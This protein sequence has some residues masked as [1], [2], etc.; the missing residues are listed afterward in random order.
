[1]PQP[2]L[3]ADTDDPP[4][5]AD[6]ISGRDVA[7]GAWGTAIV[8]RIDRPPLR[9]KGRRL[10]QHWCAT[11]GDGR[12]IIELWQRQA[13]GFVV[14]H[15]SMAATVGRTDGVRV[16]DLDAAMSYLEELCHTQ[17]AEL[18]LSGD[19]STVL[20]TLHS[21]IHFDQHFARL[22]GTALEDWSTMPQTKVPK[23]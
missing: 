15:S 16:K 6:P 18:T 22:V 2:A 17:D 11:L 7:H 10:M 9:F 3:R 1:M 14:A 21:R 23:P 5:A 19:L 20:T 4:R 12:I 8:P 13:G